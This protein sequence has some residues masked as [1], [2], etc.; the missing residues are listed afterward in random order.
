MEESKK[1]TSISDIEQT[2]KK[3]LVIVARY[4]IV[5]FIV[6]VALVYG[7]LM[8]QISNLTNKSPTTNAVQANANPNTFIHINSNEAQKLMSL[9]NN[10]VSVQTLFTQSRNNPFQD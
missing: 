1:S 7:Y 2:I 5:L 8:Y 4:K 6:V 3:Y 9:K 10:S